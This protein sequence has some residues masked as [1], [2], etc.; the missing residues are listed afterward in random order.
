MKK[1]M[2]K[3]MSPAGLCAAVALAAGMGAAVSPAAAQSCLEQIVVLQKQLPASATA[4]SSPSD[5][6]S[7][8]AQTDQ[9]PT[10]GSVAAAGVKQ[11]DSGA[12]EALNKAQNLQ[13]AGDEKGCLQAVGEARKLIDGK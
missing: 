13:A 7:V 4:S 11:P 8:A 5:R 10:P 9:Q 1:V 2:S 12:A 6:Q 3:V